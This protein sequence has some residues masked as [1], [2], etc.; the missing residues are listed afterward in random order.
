MTDNELDAIIRLLDDPD[1]TVFKILENK[2]I[3]EGT[4]VV[5][6][7]KA[8][9]GKSPLKL[10]QT[11]IKSIVHQIQQND[12]RQGLTNWKDHDENLL[13][14]AW[15]VS[16]YGY[17]D[18]QYSALQDVFSTI[19]N[20]AKILNYNNFSPLEQIK[21]INH[22]FYKKLKFVSCQTM[23]FF[24]PDNSFIAYTL[25]KRIGNPISIAIIYMLLA[26]Y[27][28][29]PVYGVNLPKNFIVAY[30]SPDD[31]RSMFY[32]NPFNQGAVL[33]EDE[34][35]FFLKQ[36]NIS[37]QSQFFNQCSNSVIIQRLLHN[38]KTSYERL[39][40]PQE[41]QEVDSLLKV[42]KNGLSAKI[43]WE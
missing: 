12:I 38:L 41:E 28:K 9:A 2:L 22:V 7:L 35:I 37:P 13:Q 33:N 40:K 26:Q 18:I 14:G 31:N 42:F 16:K 43:E 24:R 15:L 25:E 20:N 5:P 32:I 36:Q 21:F 11:R 4:G 27:C 29:I 3:S 23:D 30:V 19:A 10:M 1:N 39:K 8:A 17:P 34:I 6:R